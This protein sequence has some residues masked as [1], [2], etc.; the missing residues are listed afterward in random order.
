MGRDTTQ[1]TNIRDLDPIT[2][3]PEVEEPIKKKKN[4]TFNLSI[5]NTFQRSRIKCPNLTDPMEDG[6]WACRDCRKPI[7]HDDLVGIPESNGFIVYGYNCHTCGHRWLKEKYAEVEIRCG[8][9]FMT[10]GKWEIKRYPQN[11]KRNET[12]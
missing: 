1:E 6:G 7:P 11:N 10:L 12:V 2:D 9:S 4:T 5:S 3:F 8:Q